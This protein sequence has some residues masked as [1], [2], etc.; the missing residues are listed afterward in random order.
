MIGP[1]TVAE[2]AALPRQVAVLIIGAGFAGLASAIKLAASGEQDFLCVDR[3]PEVG[4]TWRDNTYPGAACDVP[5]QL[6]SFSFAL[7]PDWTRS[8]ST[9]PEIQDYLREVARDSGVTDR[10][11]FGVEVLAASWDSECALWRVETSAGPVAA[12]LLVSAAGA[13]SEPKLPEVPGLEDFGAA[14]FHSARWDHGQSLAG[15]RVAVI[16]TGASAIQI[17]PAIAGQ[18]AQ[19]QVYQRTAPWVLPRHD[20]EYRRLERSAMR[21]VP[22]LQRLLRNLV[23]LGREATVP[24]FIAAPKL[25][26]LVSRSAT[27]NINR[28]IAD[29]VLREK[30]RPHF[31]L[32]CKRVLISND[33]YPAL[34]RDNVEL[35]T[36][37]ISHLTR[38]TI[39]TADS[40]AR[41]VD[42]LIVATGFQATEQPIA[43]LIKGRDG[44]TLGQAWSER[45]VQGY[46]GA[47]VHGFPNLFFVVGPN[48]GL[49]HS[50]MVYM[51]E[52]QV[53]YLVDAWRQMRRHGLATVEPLAAAEQAWNA[54]LQ[55]RMRR[56]VWSTGGCRSWYL[57][58]HGRNVAL[59]PRTTY[60]FRRL[61]SSFDLGAYRSTA[62]A[63]RPEPASIP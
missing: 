29:P 18:V 28:A 22:G 63:D 2:P 12:N 51:I 42:V 3:G 60:K 52:S 35:I 17:V 32:G 33:W 26:S 13:L 19:L 53:A 31:A 55:R 27:A 45:G 34:A 44:Q 11:R 56:T 46:K 10:F 36:E 58:A 20:R 37:P 16:G 61:T 8:F 62:L 47:T 1:E 54:D 15:K 24:M 25:A 23:Y 7:N 43:D 41:E 49:G 57:D 39:V 48:T 59:W 6:Y 38:D 4:G 30:V 5:S 40:T 9:Q 14:V 50:S 21:R